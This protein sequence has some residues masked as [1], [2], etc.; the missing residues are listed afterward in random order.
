MEAYSP[1]EMF[2]PQE[3]KDVLEFWE[4]LERNNF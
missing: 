4:V 1:D 3:E 2:T